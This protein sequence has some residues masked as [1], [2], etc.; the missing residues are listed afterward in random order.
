MYTLT[1]TDVAKF[2]KQYISCGLRNKCFHLNRVYH[3]LAT[4]K[5]GRE[6]KVNGL[7]WGWGEHMLASTPHDSEKSPLTFHSLFDAH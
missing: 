4:Q 7:R 3:I 1:V 5:Q 2:C 6:Q